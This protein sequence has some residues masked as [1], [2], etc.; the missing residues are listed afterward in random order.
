MIPNNIWQTHKTKLPP[1]ESLDLIKTWFSKNPNFNWYYMDDDKCK[2][3]I[4]DHFS[5]EFVDMYNSLPYGIMKSDAWRIAVVYIYGGVYADLD[6]EC[7]HPISS[8]TEGRELVVSLEPPTRD[9]IV[10]FVFAAAPRHPALLLCLKHLIINYNGPNYLDKIV[11][12]GTP[13]QNF[14][15]A[16]FASGIKEYIALNPDDTTVKLFSIEENAFTPFRD[17]RTL[18][19]HSTGSK[20]WSHNYESWRKKQMEDFGY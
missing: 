6:T 12:T 7:I 13:I 20:F 4:E 9:G 8:W 15:Q 10:N 2:A 5:K 17:E 11:P 1:D 18:V 14:G 19:H 3:F 16:A